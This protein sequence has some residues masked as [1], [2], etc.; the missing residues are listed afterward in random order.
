M[1]HLLNLVFL[2]FRTFDRDADSYLSMNE[3]VDGLS[4]FIRGTLEEKIHCK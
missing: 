3:W 2:V 4:V 1:L